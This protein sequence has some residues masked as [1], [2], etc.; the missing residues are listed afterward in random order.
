M[1]SSVYCLSDADVNAFDNFLWRPIH[2]ACHAGHINIV[3]RLL[4]KGAD[5]NSQTIHGGTSLMR[6]MESSRVDLVRF[7][8]ERGA[9]PDLRNRSGRTA[10]DIAYDWGDRDTMLVA[11]ALIKEEKNE[12]NGEGGG[13]KGKKKEQKAKGKK[14]KGKKKGEGDEGSDMPKLTPDQISVLAPKP[15]LP[16]RLPT[17]MERIELL[18][19][20]LASGNTVTLPSVNKPVTAWGSRPPSTH[21]FLRRQQSLR[22]SQGENMVDF[23]EIRSPFTLSIDARVKLMDTEDL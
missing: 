4:E 21:E 6:A 14:G 10:L 11:R 5:I 13:K 19:Q 18:R 12:E 9:K 8:L 1:L 23:G 17:P 22:E 15:T 2:H 7:L 20:S 16:A 3:Q